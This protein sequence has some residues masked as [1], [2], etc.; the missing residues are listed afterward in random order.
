VYATGYD[1]D[2]E[3]AVQPV[4]LAKIRPE[5]HKAAFLAALERAEQDV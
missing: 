2:L 5:R 3:P 1:A 4:T